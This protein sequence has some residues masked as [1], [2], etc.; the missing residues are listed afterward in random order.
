[1]SVLN[2]MEYTNQKHKSCLL[3][4]PTYPVIN[5]TNFIDGDDW[6][7]FYGDSTEDIP[8]DVFEPRGEEVGF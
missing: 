3:L 2:M 8:P 5:K 4:D 6:K 7:E 1:M